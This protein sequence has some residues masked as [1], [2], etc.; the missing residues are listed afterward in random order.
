MLTDQEAA[1]LDVLRR[2]L[3]EEPLPGASAQQTMAP[4]QRGKYADPPPNARRASVLVLLYPLAGQLQL[5]YIQRTSPANDRHAGQIS[6]PGG[7]VEAGDKDA[8]ATALREAEE[9]VGIPR[10]A[11]E[12]LGPLTPLY[13]PVSNFLVDPFVGYLPERPSFVLQESEVARI[14][15]LPLAAFLKTDARQVGERQLVNGMRL[16]NIPFWAIDGEEVWGAT[17]MM[18]GELVVLLTA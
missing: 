17:A 2:K 18:T 7:S 9:E 1:L 14:L 13:I 15:E 16:K 8:A 6:F 11:V 4:P 5:L 10:E 12:L 3:S